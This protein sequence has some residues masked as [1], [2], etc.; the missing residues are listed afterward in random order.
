[1]EIATKDQRQKYSLK[2]MQ[3]IF[4]AVYEQDKSNTILEKM[5]TQKNSQN[6][7]AIEIA[8]DQSLRQQISNKPLVDEILSFTKKRF[9]ESSDI[10]KKME[11]A[12]RIC[13]AR[14]EESFKQY[15]QDGSYVKVAA[16]LKG[17]NDASRED[18]LT[19]KIDKY[20][21]PLT[22]AILNASGSRNK[23]YLS[24]EVNVSLMM[25]RALLEA[26][27]NITD[28]NIKYRTINN[29]ITATT[30]PKYDDNAMMAAVFSRNDEIMA[31][32]LKYASIVSSADDSRYPSMLKTIVEQALEITSGPAMSIS[33][34][35]DI[36]QKLIGILTENNYENIH[37][38]TISKICEDLKLSS[39]CKT[40][41]VTQATT[42]N[43]DANEEAKRDK[44]IK[45]KFDLLY[46]HITKKDIKGFDAVV[47]EI[48]NESPQP[49]VNSIKSI[50]TYNKTYYRHNLLIQAAW[51]NK[52]KAF[53][54]AIFKFVESIIPNNDH[55]EIF[56]TMLMAKSSHPTNPDLLGKNAYQAIETLIRYAPI[57]D[58]QKKQELAELKKKLSEKCLK[59]GLTSA[60]NNK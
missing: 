20:A 60:C 16:L 28:N 8:F 5:L 40:K 32:V 25:V 26:A 31:T 35:P 58:K 21:Y 23:G 54:D 47:N 13:D 19:T 12:T 10:Y 18:L 15:I 53:I 55:N 52:N 27:N 30:D 1:M 3:A 48:I 57:N 49:P 24:T 14:C 34:G 22:R 7:Y 43:N 59:V 9:G 41:P 56:K 46:T 37:H 42:Q 44:Y 33:D 2:S 36:T 6:K 45:D 39:E 17:I 4:D 50:L 38:F 29:M 11:D 51:S